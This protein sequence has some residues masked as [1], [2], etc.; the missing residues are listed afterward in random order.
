MAQYRRSA[1][2][3]GYSPR[4]IDQSNIQRMREDSERTARNMRERAETDISERRRTLAQTKEDQSAT[5]RME[6]KNYQIDSEN[7]RKELEGLRLKAQQ[8]SKQSAIDIEAS[9][10]IFQ[11]ISNFSDTAVKVLGEEKKQKDA[12]EFELE[13]FNKQF[14]TNTDEETQQA[15]KENAALGQDRHVT[16]LQAEEAGGFDPYTNS[17]IRKQEETQQVQLGL[18]QANAYIKNGTFIE[19]A[20]KRVETVRAAIEEQGGVA[21]Y[22][23]AKKAVGD[24]YRGAVNSLYLQGVPTSLAVKVLRGIN[25]QVSQVLKTHKDKFTQFNKNQTLENNITIFQDSAPEDQLISFPGVYDRML[26][27]HGGDHSEV[28]KDLTPSMTA[29]D[30]RTGNPIMDMTIIDQLPLTINGKETTFGEHFTNSKGQAVGIRAKV[31]KD[32]NRNRVQWDTTNDKIED[33]AAA[34]LEDELVRAVAANPTSANIA[35]AQRKYVEA[36]SGKFSSKLNNYD[37]YASIEVG[38]RNNEAQRILAKP[39]EQLTQVDVDSAK[40]V[41]TTEQSA[42]VKQRYESGNG[43]YHTKEATKIVRNATTTITGTT[44][45]GPKTASPGA[46]VAISYMEGQIRKKAKLIYGTGQNGFTVEEALTKAADDESAIYLQQ[47]TTGQHDTLPYARKLLPGGRIEFPYLEKRAGN[48]SA[49][50]KAVRDYQVLKTQVKS[51]GLQEVINIPNSFISPER[52]EYIAE[53]YG[54]PGFQPAAIERAFQG[55]TADAPLHEI[56]NRAFKA[57]GRTET[58][59]APEILKGVT[60]TPEQ[61]RIINAAER[62]YSVQTK[63]NAVN[64]ASGNT[65]VYQNPTLM[66]AGSVFNQQGGADLQTFVPQVSSVTFDTGQPGIDVFFENK[67]FPAVLGGKVKDISYQV[68]TDGSGYGHYVVIESTDPNT[69]QKVDVLYSHFGNKP[70]LQLNQTINQGQ[71][72]GIQGGSGSVQSVDGTIASIDFLAPAPRGSKSMTPYSNYESLRNSIAS[73]LQNN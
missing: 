22:E 4:R 64:V 19:Q 54:K 15:L 46:Q 69:G 72:I 3:R 10:K 61:Q 50:D 1:Q 26:W 52:M 28:W 63:L 34:K 55:M 23:D 68:N 48:V 65:A 62:T 20:N 71:I 51:L 67:Q 59:K 14:N 31:I 41:M 16:L 42:T 49:A 44:D 53:N 6:E 57:A 11:S 9:N 32:R 2:S 36:T 30:Q 7:S 17:Q 27:H 40:A 47:L 8:E 35:E 38:Q 5:R 33:E 56:Y 73:Q 43:Q 24:I 60:F 13:T 12:Y 70:N 37:K 29:V 21:T 45:F 25:T 66:R 58:F 39:D 18:A